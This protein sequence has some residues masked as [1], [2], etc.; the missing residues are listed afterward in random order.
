[1][2]FWNKTLHVSDSIAVHHQESNTIHTAIGKCHVEILKTIPLASN[3]HHTVCKQ[4]FTVSVEPIAISG[5][6][7]LF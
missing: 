6:Y 4:N 1:M 7:L 5:I 3:Q 2:I